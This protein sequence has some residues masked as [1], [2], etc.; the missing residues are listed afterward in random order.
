MINE[1]EFENFVTQI[2]LENAIT[3][4]GDANPKALLGKIIPKFPEIKEDMQHYMNSIN[5]IVK[6]INLLNLEEQKE[7]LQRI[8]PNFFDK[9]EKK[10][11]VKSKDEL[12]DLKDHKGKIRTRF[13]PAPSG[14]LHLG[15]LFGIVFNYEYVKK[16]GGEFILR[17]EDTNPENIDIKNYDKIIE[18]VKWITDDSIDEI[19]YQSDRIEIYYKYLRTLVEKGDAYICECNVEKF[20]ELIEKSNSCP[21]RKLPLKLQIENYEK[22]FNGKYKEGEA[23]VRFKADINNKNPALRDFPIA[24][25]KDEKHARLESK[26]KLWP[27]YNLCVAIDDSLMD[28]NYIIRGKDLE[29]GGTR[30]DMIKEAL[31]LKKAPYFHYGRM[32]FVDIELSKSKL[33]KR[34]ED[35]EYTGWD[36]P[37]VPSLLA[38]KK[39]GYKA[40]AFRKMIVKMGISKR[41]SKITSE[42][43][44]KNLNF[45]NKQILEKEADRFFFIEE[46]FEIEINN[47]KEFNEKEIVLPKHPTD[48]SKGFRKFKVSNSYFLEKKD[49]ENL[50]KKDIVRLMHFANFEVENK[51]ESKIILK[52]LGKNYSK[53]LNYKKTIHFLP[54]DDYE[55]IEIILP[56][57][58]TLKGISEKLPNLK[59]GESIQFERYAFLRFDNNSS[60]KKIFYY[61]HR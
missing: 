52:F 46:P 35:K 28:I 24:R 7:K 56:D 49:T 8:N 54:K 34:I 9:K 53:E 37:R 43:Y 14:H 23:I 51:T 58:E 31:N 29:I 57:N 27:M 18:D 22:F 33:T 55:E 26:Y 2:S 10:V 11:E 59:E 60:D 15:H 38:Y 3:Y 21:H 19:Y 4:S 30:Q 42:E 13:P 20:K 45:F 17:F 25:L 40:E 48:G 39:R 1:E 61:T 32:G 50:E 6:Q 16:Y 5:N 12:P 41:D 47:I 36:D 44:H